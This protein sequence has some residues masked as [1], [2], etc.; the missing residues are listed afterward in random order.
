MNIDIDNNN[1]ANLNSNIAQAICNINIDIHNNNDNAD[2]NFN[3]AKA[4]GNINIEIDNHNKDNLHI[5]ID[6]DIN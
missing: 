5:D 4:I 3:V 2:V 1:K 6:I